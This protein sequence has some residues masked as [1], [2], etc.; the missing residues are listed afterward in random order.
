MYLKKLAII[1]YKSCHD[2]VLEFKDDLP[3][4]FIGRTDAGKSTILQAIGLLLDEKATPALVQEGCE[5]SDLSSTLI[6]RKKHEEI[7]EEMKLPLFNPG[8]EESIIVVGVFGIQDGDFEGDFDE[9]ASNHLKWSVESHSVKEIV[10]MR[11]FNS[12]HLSGRYLLCAKDEVD[13]KKELWNQ[14]QPVLNK[15]IDELKITPEDITNVNKAGRFTNIEKFKAIYDR[16]KTSNQWSTYNEFGKKDRVFFPI[17]RY[18]DWREITLKSV[19]EMAKDAMSNVI[20]AYGGKLKEEAERLG[21]AATGEVNAELEKKITDILSDLP[22][23]TSIK[24]KVHFKFD[25]VISEI[26]VEKDT[27]DGEVRLESQGDGVKKKI[28]FAFMRLKALEGLV[29]GDAQK[30]FLWG[31]DEPEAHLYPPEKRDFYETIKQLSGGVFQTFISTHSTVFVDR[32]QL[33]TIQKVM[34]VDKYTRAFV[35]PSIL[36]IH[37]SLGIKNSDFLFFDVFIAGEGGSDELL[38]PHFY[39]LYFGRTIEDDFVQF[40]GLGGKDKWKENKKLFEQILDG[41]KDPQ[42]CVYYVLDRD[43]KVSEDNVYLVGKFDIEDSIAD[44]YWIRLV[45]DKCGVTLSE[46]DLATLRAKL[47]DSRDDKFG[48]LLRDKVNEIPGRSGYLP[49]KRDCAQCM[50]EY[51]VDKKDIPKDIVALFEGMTPVSE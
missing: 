32:S 34:L 5:T 46:Q 25:E 48:K 20:D 7:F 24:A 47:S 13:E 39:N 35:C 29:G 45:E 11:Q 3:N 43:T 2:L 18:I 37:E 23:V 26:S 8:L 41:F 17:Y 22:S 4:T 40:V 14:N 10:L 51:I 16:L 31:F 36:E 6:T 33:N 1:N 19:E 44:K 21:K 15:L 12:Q 50:T 49:S 42:D 27:S 9:T 38:I 30:K 28:G